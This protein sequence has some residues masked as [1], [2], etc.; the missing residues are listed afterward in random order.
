MNAILNKLPSPAFMHV[1]ATRLPMMNLTASDRRICAR[2]HLK[3]GNSIGVNVV[4]LKVP[5]AVVEGEDAHISAMV[6]VIAAH[7]GIGIVLH[8]H[9]GQGVSRDLILLVDA[10]RKVGDVEAHVFALTDEATSHHRTGVLPGNADRGADV[11]ATSNDAVL[12]HRTGALRHLQAVV[13]VVA[14]VVR[15]AVVVILQRP[16]VGGRKAQRDVGEVGAV[17][18]PG[19]VGDGRLVFALKD[20]ILCDVAGR[21]KG[22]RER[23]SFMLFQTS[24]KT[25]YRRQSSRHCCSPAGAPCTCPRG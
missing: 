17:V 5:I 9:A 4:R 19:Q 23:I 6:N 15:P 1:D 10:L 25:A 22:K 7:N 16:I 20:H 12:H 24:K 8:P 11:R 3:A 14:G 13:L 21:W 2:L 18:R